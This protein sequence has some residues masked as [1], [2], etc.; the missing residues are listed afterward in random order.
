MRKSLVSAAVLATLTFS[1]VAQ[2][3][4]IISGTLSGTIAQ[5][6]DTLGYFGVAGANHSG[7]AVSFTFSYN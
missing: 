5:G 4:E 6:I 3:A 7:A 2:A 1:G